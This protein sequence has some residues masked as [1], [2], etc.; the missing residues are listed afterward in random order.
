M[1][2]QFDPDLLRTFIA[3]AEEGTFR[4]AAERVGRTQ[5]AVSMQIQRLEQ[6]VGQPVFNR[7]RPTVQLT[8]KGEI[9]LGFARRILAV[10]HEAWNKL[11]EPTVVGSVRFGIPDDYAGGILPWIL[12]RFAADYPQ[13][14][15]DVYCATSPNLAKFATEGEIDLALITRAPP[16]SKGRL[17]RTESLV[18]AVSARSAPQLEDP[19]P[20]AV[21]Q[22]S[23]IA[24]QYVTVALTEAGRRYR[25]AYSSAHLAALIAVTEAGLAVAALP[26]SSVPK[27]FRTLGARDG[28][29][30][31][32]D[33][34]LILVRGHEGRTASVD[35]LAKCVEGISEVNATAFQ[36]DWQER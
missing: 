14:E 1:K 20:L 9:L 25:I 26:N 36:S 13:I 28:F 18:W 17:V 8:A 12:R 7:E 23:C 10:H 30:K 2:P 24:R 22:P 19:V 11:S 6:I 29:P 15:V 3:I 31:L 16:H 21:F 4:G 32:P 35:A 33:L 5:P 34:E 27:S